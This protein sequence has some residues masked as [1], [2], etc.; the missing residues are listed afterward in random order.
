AAHADGAER[1]EPAA[2]RADLGGVGEGD[3]GGPRDLARELRDRRGRRATRRWTGGA[4]GA[5][6]GL[7]VHAGA[8]AGGRGRGRNRFGR[9]DFH[10]LRACG[11]L[12]GGRRLRLGGL[13]RGRLPGGQEALTP[14]RV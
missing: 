10:R 3:G 9:G 11:L 12:P 5:G 2:G 13:L 8:V 14:V 1:V 4:G 6:G 7:A